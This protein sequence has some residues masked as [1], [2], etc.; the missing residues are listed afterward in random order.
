MFRKAVS[1]NSKRSAALYFL[2]TALTVLLLLGVTVRYFVEWERLVALWTDL[3]DTP[4]PVV[5]SRLLT[6]E[7]IDIEVQTI[8]LRKLV[9][10]MRLG[11][12]AME[13]LDN[14]LIVAEQDGKFLELT[15]NGDQTP[16][17]KRLSIRLPTNG[18]KMRAFFKSRGRDDVWPARVADLLLLKDGEHLAVSHGYWDTAG[19]CMNVRV[20]TI[21]L[22]DLFARHP[23]D[24]SPWRLV[25]NSKPC[26]QH[27]SGHEIGGRMIQQVAGKL[28]LTHGHMGASR[29]GSE[30]FQGDY[31]KILEIDLEDGSSRYISTG[32]RNEQGLAIDSTGTLWSTEHGP[33]GGDELNIIVSGGDYG[34]PYV[35]YGT[36]YNKRH[37][38]YAKQQGRHNGYKKP[39]FAWLPSIAVSN[40]I[41]INDFHV[42]WDADLLVTSLKAKS[43]HRLRLDG[44][45]VQ[46]EERIFLGERLRDILQMPDGAIVIWTD[47]NKI[48]RMTGIDPADDRAKVASLPAGARKTVTGCLQCHSL[49]EDLS[50]QSKIS[51]FGL[52]KRR[53]ADGPKHL[54]SLEFREFGARHNSWDRKLLDKFLNDPERFVPGSSMAGNGIPDEITR[55]EVLN[56]LETLE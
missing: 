17:A 18:D 48:I 54:Y 14:T 41:Q 35:T 42:R 8:L 38:P 44:E 4:K 19:N 32:H 2:A 1:Q 25:F 26:M 13:R 9:P 22:S 31:G 40:L 11:A 36:D 29:P 10:D 39:V 45:R 3:H 52:F 47:G 12:G 53:P 30:E 49:T 5:S 50:N 15:L 34:W 51:L 7:L 24:H 23:P 21:S 28:I 33:Q 43:L 37:W 27:G 46:Y 56:F 16:I 55:K 20:V 6:T